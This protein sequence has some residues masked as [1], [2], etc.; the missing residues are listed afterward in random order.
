MM[1]SVLYDGLKIPKN[2]PLDLNDLLSKLLDK[3]P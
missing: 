1:N 3:N 2:I